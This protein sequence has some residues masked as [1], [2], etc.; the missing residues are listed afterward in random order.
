MNFNFVHSFI[1]SYYKNSRS[2]NDIW[3]IRLKN[4]TSYLIVLTINRWNILVSTYTVFIFCLVAYFFLGF[5]S[6]PVLFCHILSLALFSIVWSKRSRERNV[7]CRYLSP[8][9]FNAV[10]HLKA[11]VHGHRWMVMKG[12]L[13]VEWLLIIFYV[14][15]Q[16]LDSSDDWEQ[17]RKDIM[18]Q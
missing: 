7:C 3:K 12:C 4:V 11:T 1:H 14:K 5:G 17:G 10:P 9:L 13:G 18:R 6:P 2:F 8:R 16:P 15:S